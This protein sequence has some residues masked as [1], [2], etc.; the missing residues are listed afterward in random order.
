MKGMSAKVSR[1]FSHL[2]FPR[3][4]SHAIGTPAITSKA[5]TAKAMMKEFVMATNAR[6]MSDGWS[7]ICDMVSIFVKI[8][9]MGGSRINARKM[10]IA[11][12]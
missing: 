10:I 7:K 11:A 4:I 12:M 2:D 5:E 6:S 3:V 9:S 1:M 8:P